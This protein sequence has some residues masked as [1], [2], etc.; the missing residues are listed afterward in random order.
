MGQEIK[1]GVQK[2]VSVTK[3]LPFSEARVL[4]PWGPTRPH[5]PG[6]GLLCLKQIPGSFHV[7]L[8]ALLALEGH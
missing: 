3:C 7:S 6:W 5:A 8:H 1:K 2:C 4:A